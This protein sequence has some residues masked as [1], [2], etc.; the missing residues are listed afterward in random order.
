MFL[1]GSSISR[2][3]Y[4]RILIV[5]HSLFCSC[6][7][8]ICILIPSNSVIFSQRRKLVIW[9][10][11]WMSKIFLILYILWLSIVLLRVK[12][13]NLNLCLATV[14]YLERIL[15]QILYNITILYI[16]YSKI[17]KI[18]LL[19]IYIT[20]LSV[21][22]LVWTIFISSNVFCKI[23]LVVMLCLFVAIYQ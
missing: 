22:C 19:I 15:L 1:I 23:S 9:C 20:C 12:R 3:V 21:I 7:K 8:Q 10:W 18:I 11:S 17:N 5:D 2:L 14:R 4:C 13:A 16:W 6:Y